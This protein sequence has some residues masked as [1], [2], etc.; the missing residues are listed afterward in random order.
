MLHW[1][2]LQNTNNNDHIEHPL[3]LILEHLYP[4]QLMLSVTFLLIK[5]SLKTNI[6]NGYP[7]KLMLR[8]ASLKSNV[9]FQSWTRSRDVKYKEK[10][11]SMIEVWSTTRNTELLKLVE[12]FADPYQF[13]ILLLYFR[14][15]EFFQK[16]FT[17]KIH[18][19]YWESKLARWRKNFS[20]ENC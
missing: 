5:E 9:Q 10:L 11:L 13:P 16:K 14:L 1:T 19:S 7:L 2:K 8:K 17:T 3:I 20:T 6:Q 15:N 12:I 18:A 4:L